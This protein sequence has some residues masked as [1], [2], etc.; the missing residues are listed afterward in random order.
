[1]SDTVSAESIK[2]QMPHVTLK[3]ILGEP[4]HCQLKQLK[5]K[6]TANLI[7]SWGHNKG[8]L[9]LLQDLVLYLQRN[10]TAFTI[11][12]TAPPA[13]PVIVASATTAEHKEQHANIISACK[14]WSTYMIIHTITRDQ[15]AGTIDDVYYA[16]I[17]DPTEGLNAV[18]L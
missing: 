4:S 11:P 7:Y 15:F 16:T 2:A 18:T 3:R 1:M 5:R 13:Y 6:L 9:G 8:H 14:A 10:G 12:A 17:N